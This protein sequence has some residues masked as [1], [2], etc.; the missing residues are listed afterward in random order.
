MTFMRPLICWGAVAVLVAALGIDTPA[1][2]ETL[3]ITNLGP[4]EFLSLPSI[5]QN[6]T[7]LAF[8]TN[9]NVAGLNAGGIPN[10]FVYDGATQKFTRVTS[11]G[12]ADPSISGNGRF[13]AFTSSA[14]YVRRNADGSDEIFRYDRVTKRFLQFTRD[15]NGD[16]SSELPS[17]DFKGRKVAFETTSNIHLRNPDLSPEVYLSNRGAN[18]PMSKD[19]NGD[20]ES[21]NVAISS[22]GNFVSFESTS[23]LTGHNS[24][25]SQELMV[26]DVKRRK[27]SQVTNDTEGAGSSGTS[28]ISG[29]GRYV[30]FISS[31]NLGLLN[32][33][34]A[35]AV[36]LINRPRH[37]FAVLTTTLDGVFDGDTPTINDDG[38]WIAFASGFNLANGNPDFNSEIL[39][40]DRSHKTFTQLTNSSGCFN[41]T[42]K[43]SGDGT[44]IAF[45]SNCDLTGANADGTQEV[46]LVDN[47][48][49]HLGV[50]SEGPVA[51]TVTDPDGGIIGPFSN[52]IARASYAQ[53]DFNGNGQPEDRVRIPQAPE[54]TYHIQAFADANAQPTDPLTL[55]VSLNGTAV[56]LPVA[57][58]ADTTGVDFTFGNQTFKAASSR[59]T[60]LGGIGSYVGLGARLP[61]PPATTG[62][63]RVHFTD[64]LNDLAFDLGPIE[65]FVHRGSYRIFNGTFNGFVVSCRI[66]KRLNGT[67]T[68]GFSARHGD[69][70]MF[71]GTTDESMTMIVQIG[72]DADMYTWRFKR[73]VNGNL[74]LR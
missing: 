46:F 39:L 48:A 41:G 26:Y 62:P 4:G 45:L 55:S 70:S 5:S 51:L 9:S 66:G 35:S 73:R 2:A 40:Y 56:A 21:H 1:A 18:T 29:D 58:V 49:L 11:Q 7:L 8:G 30:V 61:H 33:D 47:P 27:V 14:D 28:A 24:D 50:D 19:P 53:G 54:G 36:Y 69:L 34:G 44:R 23:D 6:G 13:V 17:T 38:R 57:T 12:G 63:V 25:F 65:N 59:M 52:T 31:S 72:A 60:P 10:V 67:L 43:I 64:G 42:P 74:V 71:T 68:F 15:N 22:D 37:D 20:G 16:G 32:P 3:Q